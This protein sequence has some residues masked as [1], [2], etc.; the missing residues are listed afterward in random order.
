MNCKEIRDEILNEVRK[1]VA[2]CEI[3]DIPAP[4]LVTVQFGDNKVS[5]RY[6]KNKIKT[7]DSVGLLQEHVKL[8]GNFDKN[9]A[10]VV[11]D[12]LYDDPYVSGV[13]VQLPIEI[14]G[15]DNINVPFE[16]D[17]DGL[18][19]DS[20]ESYFLKGENTNIPCT[21]KAVIDILQKNN[22]S[23]ESEVVLVLGKGKTSGH[24]LSLMLQR[25]GATVINVNSKTFKQDS[26][27]LLK[28]ASIVV[29]C[30]GRPNILDNNNLVGDYKAI[31]NVG[32]FNDEDG[33]LIGDINIGS[34]VE[35]RFK[36]TLITPLVGG[37]GILTVANLLKN[38][39]LRH[40]QDYKFMTELENIL[41]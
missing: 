23:V 5:E 17:V 8:S 31:I 14:E 39:C 10:K 32:M 29:S 18:S 6:I 20:Y 21:A 36:D 30:A 33:K 1:Y 25:L 38:T 41:S 24:P 9:I 16:K 11:L 26:D 15:I 28:M 40:Y 27:K 12:E 13:M 35:S 7:C 2:V 37:T 19:P 4:K 34:L 3:Y 22:I